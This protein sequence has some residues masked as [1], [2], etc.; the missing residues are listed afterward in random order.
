MVEVTDGGYAMEED[1]V[2]GLPRPGGTVEDD[3]LLCVLR[4]GARQ[5]LTHAIEAEV[6]AFLAAHAERV[7]DHGRR[8]L[9]RNGHAPTRTLQ[10]GIGAIEVRRPRVRDRGAGASGRMGSTSCRASSTPGSACWS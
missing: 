9:V 10:T 4:A 3:P 5:M 8:R 7:D 1:T 6:A 2:V